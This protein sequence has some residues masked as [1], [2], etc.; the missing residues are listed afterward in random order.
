MET[1][2]TADLKKILETIEADKK[3]AQKMQAMQVH[4]QEFLISQ[5]HGEDSASSG[6][7]NK[8]GTGGWYPNDIKVDIPE[9]DGKLDP[10]EFM[11]WLPIVERVFDY[12]DNKVKI[13]A[14]KLRK[15][16]STWWSNTCLKRERHIASE[17]PNKRMISL[18]N[19][20]LARSFEFEPDLVAS[21]ESPYDNE[22]EVISPDEGP[23]LVVRRTLSTTPVSE[24]EL[25]RESI[26]HTRS[27]TLLVS[28]KNRE[29]RM[30][31]DS[32]LI[33]RNTIKYRFPIPR[34]NDLLD[35]LHGSTVF[36]KVDLRSGYHHIHIYEGDEWKTTFKTKEGLYERLVMPFKLSN[37]Q[38]TFMRL[39]NHLLKPFLGSVDRNNA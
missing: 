8:R 26:F 10:D 20:E 25:Q 2:N 1:Q 33:N 34:L 28:K 36:S 21:S 11:E 19:F 39:M 12:K 32:R 37:A 14:L 16:A 7:V 30:C 29:W 4:I 6:S 35:E 3:M 15:C 27:P 22:V 38:N 31:M 9:Y 17:C 24:T 23:Y 5:N 13:V 18:A